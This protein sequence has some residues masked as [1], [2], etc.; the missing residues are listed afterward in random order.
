MQHLMFDGIQGHR[1]RLDDILLMHETLERLPRILGMETT[2]PPIVT[3][4]YNGFDPEDCGLSGFVFLPGGH[5]TLH[6]FSMREA[7]FA[8]ILTPVT[9]Q[10]STA[11]SLILNSFPCAQHSTFLESRGPDTTDSAAGCTV[12]MDKDFGPHLF[13]E[14]SVEHL[15][16]TMDWLFIAL[17]TLPGAIGMTP[18]MR[19]YVL[20]NALRGGASVV[21]GLTMIAESH[22][23]VHIF[24][25][26]R[27]AFVD[28]FSCKFF[29]QTS[30]LHHL[31]KLFQSHPTAHSFI[32]RGK[33][34]SQLR[35]MAADRYERF[36][37][38]RNYCTH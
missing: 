23:A 27:N 5:V 2:M 16:P 15:N 22:I 10:A 33:Q 37:D 14:Y 19:P 12:D 7:V 13:A 30:V 1:S 26:T 21:S 25:P 38:W 35:S 31:E 11:E 6:T 3:P 34:F 17:D 18:I 20:S 28:I 24:S 32:S 4:Y 9:I 29:D 8:D 36:G